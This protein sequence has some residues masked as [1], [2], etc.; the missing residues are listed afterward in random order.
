MTED[1]QLSA[2]EL[3]QKFQERFEINRDNI[4]RVYIEMGNCLMG[5]IAVEILE[6]APTAK[7][8][9]VYHMTVQNNE[10][11][12]IGVEALLNGEG[13]DLLRQDEDSE[14]LF[15]WVEDLTCKYSGDYLVLLPTTIDLVAQTKLFA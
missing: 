7:T 3:K 6:K 1:I 4:E 9:V 2:E 8:L 15:R 5:Q 13:K 10:Y 12:S 14:E 11:N